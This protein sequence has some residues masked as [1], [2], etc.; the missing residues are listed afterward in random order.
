VD[1]SG[2]TS[3]EDNLFNMTIHY[4]SYKVIKEYFEP[5]YDDAKC[6]LFLALL[7]SRSLIV[8]RRIFGIKTVKILET[9]YHIVRN[10]VDVF[11]KIGNKSH[12]KDRNVACRPM[13][14]VTINC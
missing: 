8:V 1:E 5:K 11:Q 6:Q 7:K 3:L 2:I 14:L 9:S 12:S 4:H 13:C 10:L